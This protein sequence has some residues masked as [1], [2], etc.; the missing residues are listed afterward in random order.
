VKPR[1]QPCKRSNCPDTSPYS[2]LSNQPENRFLLITETKNALVWVHVV[3]NKVSGSRQCSRGGVQPWDH[4]RKRSQCPD[5]SPFSELSNQPE[6]RF[7]LFTETKNA[8]VW[9]HVVQN[10]VSGSWQCSCGGVQPRDQPCKRSQCPDTSP[11]SELSNQPGNRFSLFIEI[12][13]ALVW[14][15]MVQK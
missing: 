6:N 13:N 9:C 11:F 5:T 12:K 4:P 2:E 14:C 3:Q 7:L 10:K 8:L 15:H 1:D